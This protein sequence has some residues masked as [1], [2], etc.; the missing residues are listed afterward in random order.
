MPQKHL[1]NDVRSCKARKS[2]CYRTEA[3]TVIK[4]GN[5]SN[6]MRDNLRLVCPNCDSQLDTYKSKNKGNGRINRRKRYLEEKNIMS[7]WY[8]F[9]WCSGNTSAFGAGFLSSNLDGKTVAVVYWLAHLFVEQL[10]RV[11]IP[12]S[13]YIFLS[14]NWIGPDTTDIKMGVWISPRKLF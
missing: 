2:D 6:N 14:F 4:Y 1:L 8:I 11:R 12:L 3:L 13:L 7:D 9:P 5:S 10:D